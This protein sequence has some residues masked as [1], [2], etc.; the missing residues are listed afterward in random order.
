MATKVFQLPKNEGMSHIFENLSTKAY[1]KNDNDLF[2][3]TET[4]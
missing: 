2:V 3:V 1:Q 4:I